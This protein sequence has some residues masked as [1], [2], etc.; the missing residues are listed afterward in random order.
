MYFFLYVYL[1]IYLRCS[2]DHITRPVLAIEEGKTFRGRLNTWMSTIKSDLLVIRT[3]MTQ[4]R[5]ESRKSSIWYIFLWV[6]KLAYIV[7]FTYEHV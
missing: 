4:Y 3:E 6:Y 2:E 7:F 1:V 5:Q